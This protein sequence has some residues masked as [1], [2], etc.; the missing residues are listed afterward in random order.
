[1]EVCACEREGGGCCMHWESAVCGCGGG[2]G[3][4]SPMLQLENE[5]IPV[6]Q[7]LGGI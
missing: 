6:Q 3:S 2:G 1:M 4:A 5:D 7:Q